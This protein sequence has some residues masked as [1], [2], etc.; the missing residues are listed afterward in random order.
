VYQSIWKVHGEH[1]EYGWKMMKVGRDDC[2]FKVS[3]AMQ[4]INKVKLE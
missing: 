4:G 2:V 3:M 1:V